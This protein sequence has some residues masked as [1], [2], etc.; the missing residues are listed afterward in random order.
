MDITKT[1]YGHYQN[2]AYA[3]GTLGLRFNLTAEVMAAGLMTVILGLVAWLVVHKTLQ[4]GEMMAVLTLVGTIIPAV[5]S[6]SL[7]NIQ[8]QEAHIAFDQMYEYAHLTPEQ[9]GHLPDASFRFESLR[10]DG[11]DFR[12]SGQALLFD[13][14]SLTLCRGEWVALVGESGRGK[15]TLLQ[16]LQRF[17]EAEKGQFMLNGHNWRTADTPTWRTALG[18]VP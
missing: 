1:V 15:G 14:V 11:L 6:L 17:Y 18:V 13:G 8:L 2:R 10:I 5:I 3:L 16:V 9:T 12:F 4:L 7:T